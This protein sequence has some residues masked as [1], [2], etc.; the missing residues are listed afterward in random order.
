ML[1]NCEECGVVFSHPTRDLCQKCHEQAQKHFDTVKQFLRENPGAT[2][3][4]VAQATE[5][6][7]DLIYEYI[8]AGR[9][10]VIPKD[11]SLEC[12]ICGR[13]IAMGKVCSLCRTSLQ[14]GT[15]PESSKKSLDSSKMH[16][17]EQIRKRK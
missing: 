4:Q 6:D 3:A 7:L 17:L 12:T 16:I 15:T 13:P 9:L 11:A 8:R 10:D 14:K 5:V 2:T 1:R